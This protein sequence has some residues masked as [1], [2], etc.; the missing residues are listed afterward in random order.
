[1][2]SEV[3]NYTVNEK[4]VVVEPGKLISEDAVGQ[5]EQM[6]VTNAPDE[7]KHVLLDFQKVTAITSRGISAIIGCKKALKNTPYFMGISNLQTGLKDLLMAMNINRI[8]PFFENNDDF[9]IAMNE[10]EPEQTTEEVK[11]LWYRIQN[12]NHYSTIAITSRKVDDECVPVETFTGMRYDLPVVI[13]LKDIES[14]TEEAI[15]LIFT[16]LEK[17]QKN[18]KQV[19]FMNTSQDIIDLIQLVSDVSFETV[20]SVEEV[21]KK[22]RP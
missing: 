12:Y 9:I 15:Q 20:E 18:G 21:E 7:R 19:F 16:I 3:V 14:L 4:Y 10:F 13:R 17:M 2:S 1:M 11:H 8:I 6:L 22:L 5:F